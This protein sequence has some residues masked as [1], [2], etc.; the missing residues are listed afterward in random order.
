MRIPLVCAPEEGWP[1]ID[2]VLHNMACCSFQWRLFHGDAVE[3]LVRLYVGAIKDFAAII[4]FLL[5]MNYGRSPEAVIRGLFALNIILGC[6][7]VL[8]ELL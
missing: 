4:G 1:C 2:P 5:R 7:H 3:F 6:V 8:F